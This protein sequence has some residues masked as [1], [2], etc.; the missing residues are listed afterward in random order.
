[1]S[2]ERSNV[3]AVVET[4]TPVT[5]STL[6]SALAVPS[7]IANAGDRASRRF[8][9]FFAASIE[10][11]NTRMAYYR[12][13]CSFFAWVDQHGIGGLVDIEPSMSLRIS[14]R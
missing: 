5:T 9:D 8:L 12:A 7:M 10:N 13:V 11:D 2:A 6:R 3:P 1:V 4:A 14:R